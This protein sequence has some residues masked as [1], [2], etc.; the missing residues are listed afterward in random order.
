MLGKEK[1][2]I[3]KEIRQR[4][5]DENDIPWV[6]QEC[7]HQ[8]SCRG[9]CPKCESELRELERQL[10]ARQAMGKRVAVAALCAG[11]A[12][13]SVGCSNPLTR[14][15]FTDDTGGALP[16]PHTMAPTVTPTPDPGEWILE[17]EVPYDGELDGRIAPTEYP[18]L[19]GDVAWVEPAETEDFELAGEP[20]P[21]EEV[22]G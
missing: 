21:E 14:G 3:L 17:G 4:I 5:A 8:G 12:F 13:T 11:M 2:K 1:C 20:L 15:S 16:A 22:H 19:E 7:R 10:A 6:T 9:T 18:E